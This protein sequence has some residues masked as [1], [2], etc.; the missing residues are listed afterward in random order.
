MRHKAAAVLAASVLLLAACTHNAGPRVASAA[1][2]TAL[3]SADRA[4]E[5]QAIQAYAQCMRQHGVTVNDP[6]DIH[7]PAGGRNDPALLA[8]QAAQDACK[9]LMPGG[10]LVDGPG[11]QEIEQLRTFAACMREHDI[12]I[13][14]PLPNG[15]MKINGR[16]D[17]VTRTQLEADP[18][19]IAAMAACRDKLPVPTKSGEPQR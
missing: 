11:L 3:P 18:V 16:F 4:A 19:Y 5:E 17:H 1:S 7:P 8:W 12:P 15:N 6:H 14:D 9:P 2:P 13:T 10:T